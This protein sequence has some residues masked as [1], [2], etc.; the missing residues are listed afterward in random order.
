MTEAAGSWEIDWETSADTTPK[1]PERVLGVA[2]DAAAKPR[3]TET[4]ANGA[5]DGLTDLL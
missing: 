3:T 4:L 5:W 1:S 2:L